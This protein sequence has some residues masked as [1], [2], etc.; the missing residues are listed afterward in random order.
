LLVN[1]KFRKK[2]LPC[3]GENGIIVADFLDVHCHFNLHEYAVPDD[4]PADIDIGIVS[5]KGYQ[6]GLWSD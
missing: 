3:G 4:L 2:R 6:K 1:K 5:S